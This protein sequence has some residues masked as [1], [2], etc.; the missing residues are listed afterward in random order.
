MVALEQV[1]VQTDSLNSG[2]AKVVG[3]GVNVY[4]GDAQALKWRRP[5]HSAN[6]K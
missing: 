1:A 5:G 2:Q 6:A 4:Y 3:R